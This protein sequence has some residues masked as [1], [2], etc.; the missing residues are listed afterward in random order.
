MHFVFH[1]WASDDIMTFAYLKNKK[2]C[3]SEKKTLFL[4][5][6]VLFLRYTKQ[7]NFSF[8]RFFCFLQQY[9]RSHVLLKS[10][11]FF[12][13]FQ[14]KGNKNVYRRQIRMADL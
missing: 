10:F 14:V 1:A 9:S 4:I 12:L 3:Q 6:Q 2:G 11:S 5:S 8:T 13:E 7:T